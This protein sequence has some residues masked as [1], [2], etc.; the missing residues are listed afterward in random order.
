[1]F[2]NILVPLDGS[3]LAE[4]VL[5]HVVALGLS[6]RIPVTLVTVLDPATYAPARH[7]V[8]ALDWQFRKSEAEAY[9]QRLASRLKEV[10]I[11]SEVSILEGQAAEQII[12]FANQN[13]IDLIML[14]SHGQSG[15]SEWN[16]SSVV[17]KVIIRANA[18]TMII[19]AHQ[20]SMEEISELRYHKI[21]MPVDGSQR[22]EVVVPV[23]NAIARAHEA[24][25][26][27]AHVIHRP[28][29][30][31][32]T[33]LT[34]DDENLIERLI[35]RNRA[36]A[37]SYLNEIQNRIDVK[38]ETRMLVS[39]GVTAALHDLVDQEEIDL[40]VLSAHGYSGESRFPYGNVVISF[41]AYGKSP[42]L[43]IQD[44]PKHQTRTVYEDPQH[45]TEESTWQ[46]TDKK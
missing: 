14:S 36:K 13:Q 17:Q 18:S 45:H 5:P 20:T 37:F 8:D 10:D 22:A 28:D 38:A 16:V 41:L 2:Q 42:L 33:P 15:L 46:L 26:V 32:R 29:M 31:R 4:R 40:V 25:V 19:R 34:P 9:L 6:Q 24:Q 12:Q 7:S 21:L 27:L 30:P 39:G 11:R 23:V 1:M 44:M 3:T 35:E 43:V